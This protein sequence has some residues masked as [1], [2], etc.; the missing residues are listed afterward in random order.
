MSRDTVAEI[1]AEAEKL[2]ERVES[3]QEIPY[4]LGGELVEEI[5]Q[6]A[7]VA[8]RLK[9]LLYDFEW[10]RRVELTKAGGT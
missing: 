1:V 3:I 9:E 8:D 6:A 4:E 10:Q 5:G 7:R 2:I